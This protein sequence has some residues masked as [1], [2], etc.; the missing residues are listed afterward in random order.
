MPLTTDPTNP[1][2]DGDGLLDGEE[3][4]PAIR[5]SEKRYY[6]ANNCAELASKSWN[7]AFDD[8]LDAK[9]I[10]WLPSKFKDSIGKRSGSYTIDFNDE[11]LKERFNQ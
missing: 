4:D 6:L 7:K 1:D 9:S 5:W 10:T 8:D 11:I 2:T 3:I